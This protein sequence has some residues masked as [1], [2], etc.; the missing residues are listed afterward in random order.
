MVNHAMIARQMAMILERGPS[1]PT[2]ITPISIKS[3]VKPIVISET[4]AKLVIA[5]RAMSTQKWM[6]S[7]RSIAS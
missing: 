4:Y 3:A 6:K 2:F 5:I 7:M 1:R